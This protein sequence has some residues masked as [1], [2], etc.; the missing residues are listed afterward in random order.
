M[1]WLTAIRVFF[2]V[3]FSAQLAEQV[4]RLLDGEPAR[5]VTAPLPEAKPAPKKPP[6]K[7]AERNAAIGLLAALQ[8]EARFV[9]FINEPLAGYSDAQ[10][11]AA[12]RDVHRDCGIVL[13]RMFALEPLLPGE[14]GAEVEVPKGF[15]AGLYRLTGNVA[16]EPPF[17]GTM[18]H[19]GWR[20]SVCELPQW[21]GS[22]ESARVVAP[23]EV[24][25]R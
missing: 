6:A 13:A 25:L 23:A 5:T 4:K 1:R 22:A 18:V 9:D 12:A 16:G 2:R 15:D 19:H 14:E 3:L 11:G 21:S 24:E 7:P 17:R 20:A 8:R 10:I